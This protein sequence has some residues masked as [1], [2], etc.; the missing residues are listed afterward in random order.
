MALGR[1]LAVGA[2]GDP[3][4]VFAALSAAYTVHADPV[5]TTLW[6]WLDTADWRLHRA[7][8][9]LREERRGRTRELIL[10]RPSAPV[11]SSPVRGISW[12][13]R[14]DKLPSSPVLEQIVG[15]VGVR[16]LL[17]L[18]EVEARRILLR[19]MDGVG[20]TRVR[21]SVEQQRLLAPRRSALP[22][23][24]VVTALRGY[25][26]DAQRCVELL[27]ESMAA[28][29]TTMSP[30]AAALA[31]AGHLPSAAGSKD[32][33]VAPTDPAVRPVA[34]ALLR[35]VGIVDH[36]REGAIADL[37]TEFLH[38]LR[39]AIRSTRALL[40]A[41]GHLL[42]GRSAIRVERDLCW[43][44]EMTTPLRAVD[45]ALLE[46]NGSDGLDVAGLPGL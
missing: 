40:T 24:V 23:H 26:R 17:P 5:E 45:I 32:V 33:V 44:D 4:A 9:A 21:V 13:G 2:S 15:V 36:T 42:P 43:L 38:D 10:D 18:A 39:S 30:T 41:A 37:D 25:D 12:P 27:I 46:I 11:I 7:D 6:T 22:L 20:K 31:A 35:D 28:E 29:T 8:L 3:G 19:L 14:L 16:A 34:R 1:V